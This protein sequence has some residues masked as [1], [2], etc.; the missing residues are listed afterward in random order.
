MLTIAELIRHEL[1]RREF[2]PVVHRI[3]LVVDDLDLPRWH[4]ETDRG[5]TEAVV[6]VD[7]GLLRLGERGLLVID[8]HGIRFLIPD[9]AALDENSRRILDT[10]L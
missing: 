2:V 7:D 6:R 10:Y 9:T 1:T 4:L 5:A 3:D 8:I